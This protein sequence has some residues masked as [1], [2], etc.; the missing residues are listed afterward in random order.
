[1]DD[2]VAEG[3][4]EVEVELDFRPGG[5]IGLGPGGKGQEKEG[6][7]DDGFCLHA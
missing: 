2:F 5:D 1:M 3:A 6:P 4:V 7:A